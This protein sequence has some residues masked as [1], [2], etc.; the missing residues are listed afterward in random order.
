M[1]K[2]FFQKFALLNAGISGQQ[3]F[4]L[5]LWEEYIRNEKTFVIKDNIYKF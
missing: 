1:I 4:R 3:L 5:E 2:N